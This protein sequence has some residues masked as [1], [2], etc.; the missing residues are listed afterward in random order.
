MVQNTKAKV[1]SLPPKCTFFC[2]MVRSVVVNG[3]GVT[4]SNGHAE[5]IVQSLSDGGLAHVQVGRRYLVVFCLGRI[6]AVYR[7]PRIPL[8]RLLDGDDVPSTTTL[9]KFNPIYQ[10]V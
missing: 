4:I 6:V 2:G 10:K 1:V 9:A 7:L 5:Y 3:R 8:I